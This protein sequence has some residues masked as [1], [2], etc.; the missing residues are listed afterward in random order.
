V[1]LK[2]VINQAI[3]ALISQRFRA[4]LTMLGI[5][6]GIVTVV[7]LM[8]YGNGFHSALVYGFR[9]AYSDGTV[10]VFGGQ[11]S[12]QAGGERAGKPVRMVEEDAE[13]IK[14]LGLVK[15]ASPEYIRT[16]VIAYGNRQTSAAVRGVAPEYGI[17]RNEVA[18]IGRF[19]NQED[20]E[21]RRRVVFFGTEVARKLFGNSSPVGETVRINGMSFE[22]VGVMAEKV[23]M[24]TY[25]SPDKYCAFIPN[26]T[27]G[28]LWDNKYLYSLV[29]Q[30]V[31]V[32]MHEQAV[33][34]VKNTL[35]ARHGFDPRDER[36][37]ITMDSVEN[38]QSL[39]GI[40]S[41]LKVVLGFIGTLTLMIG[42]VGVMNI[43]LVSVTERTREIGIRKALGARRRNILAQ[44]LLEGIAITFF[45]GLLGVALSYLLVAII[46]SRPFLADLLED[47]TRRT[48][49]ILI[50]S[51]D[52][53]LAAT[54]ILVFVGLLSGLWPAMRASRLD[55][56]TSLRYE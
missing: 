33:K 13:A 32:S 40:T 35:A 47:P 5:A 10:V 49:V 4:S 18:E 31:D 41:G 3:Y 55:P 36:A 39:S 50:L 51:P 20:A 37:I 12:L 26:T 45:G 46:G 27:V 16:L 43:M 54:G 34:Q 28:Q 1:L 29:F 56:I 11:T 24:G 44:F 6:W 42:G 52:V 23:Q 19:I 22:V 30:S 21:K 25:Y 9:G 2:E 14:D 15:Y 53:L 17:M 8:A 48:D 38:T 7:L